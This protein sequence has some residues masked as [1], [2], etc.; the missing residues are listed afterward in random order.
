MCLKFSVFLKFSVVLFI[1]KTTLSSLLVMWRKFDYDALES[2]LS[3]ILISLE[4]KGSAALKSPLILLPFSAMNQQPLVRC[5]Q[6]KASNSNLKPDIC[7]SVKAQTVKH[8]CLTDFLFLPS[9][10]FL[11]RYFVLFLIS[12]ILCSGAYMMAY[13]I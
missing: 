13:V 10:C 12:F 7:I 3:M 9:Q 6:N 8:Y 11:F 4:L 2:F 5:F 1:C